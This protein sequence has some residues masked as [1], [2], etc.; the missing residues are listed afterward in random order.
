MHLMSRAKPPCWLY[1]YF[2]PDRIEVLKER[3]IR[4]TPPGS[5]NDPFDCRTPFS[6]GVKIDGSISLSVPIRI[7]PFETTTQFSS[8]NE[9]YLSLSEM[10][11]LS[12]SAPVQRQ[13]E[14]GRPSSVESH[15]SVHKGLNATGGFAARHA[16]RSLGILS[17]SERWDSGLM[18]SH[19][20][21]SYCGLV[22]GFDAT[23]PFI[24]GQDS[25]AMAVSLDVMVEGFSAVAT[26]PS[27]LPVLYDN[28]RVPHVPNINAT[29][30]IT[31][32]DCLSKG[33]DWAYEREWRAFRSFEARDAV[34]FRKR[35]VFKPYVTGKV[36]VFGNSIVLYEFP[37]EAIKEVIVGTFMSY[38][39][40]ARIVE[41]M[42][43]DPSLAHVQ[44]STIHL[45][46]DSYRLERFALTANELGA[47]R[48][49]NDTSGYEEQLRWE[50]RATFKAIGPDALIRLRDMLRGGAL[51]PPSGVEGQILMD[52][53]E[54][55]ID[56]SPNSKCTKK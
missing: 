14:A 27:V 8:R 34:G 36:D 31:Y 37:A 16:A 23:H 13:S 3:R 6:L 52:V 56:S 44:L 41:I 38:R 1:K 28:D 7:G 12:E 33:A 10:L 40:R 18:W 48:H 26:G 55:T 45:S 4:F 50:F 35:G 47:V 54:E 30:V 39:D 49:A 24:A 51:S 29:S 19:Y 2:P 11:T 15:F 20:A 17:L 46:V 22:I 43:S 53:L 32:A 21:Q 9:Q 42:Q 25:P 5:F